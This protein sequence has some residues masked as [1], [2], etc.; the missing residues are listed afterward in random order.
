MACMAAILR[1]PTD[2]LHQA[3]A[4]ALAV[5]ATR[6]RFNDMGNEVIASTPEE[7]SAVIQGEAPRWAKFVK[8][9]RIK[10]D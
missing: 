2:R 10:L 3:T 6:K 7:F 8:E 9:N 4:R 5:S 1:L